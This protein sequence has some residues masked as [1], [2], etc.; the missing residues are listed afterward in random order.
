M[1]QPG[2]EWDVGLPLG[3]PSPPSPPSPTASSGSRSSST[4]ALYCSE[5]MTPVGVFEAE[6]QSGASPSGSPVPTR[7][8]PGYSNSAPRFL[9]AGYS[10]YCRYR[11]VLKRFGA[12]AYGMM[13]HPLVQ[14]M[15][16]LRVPER[17]TLLVF[18]RK[19]FRDITLE[20]K[21]GFTDG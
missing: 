16:G 4:V 10:Q 17:H 19:T 5:A 15:G 9:V 13:D 8:T 7:A 21:L 6:D 3:P 20:R 18:M 2:A 12:A 11:A 1:E 14:A